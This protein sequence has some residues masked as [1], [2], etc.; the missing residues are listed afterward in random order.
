MAINIGNRE[1]VGWVH[2]ANLTGA[3][4]NTDGTPTIPLTPT[5]PLRKHPHYIRDGEV[6]MLKSEFPRTNMHPLQRHITETTWA[7]YYVAEQPVD[8][9]ILSG[10]LGREPLRFAILE[11]IP[12][13]DGG[14]PQGKGIMGALHSS[15]SGAVMWYFI[16]QGE[17]FIRTAPAIGNPGVPIY[18]DRFSQNGLEE[19]H[20]Q[21]N[22]GSYPN[23]GLNMIRGMRLAGFSTHP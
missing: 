13:P 19:I 16:S 6:Q 11:G 1:A 2:E 4:N 7:S 3:G 21:L 5:S 17:N 8:F 18:H 14:W 22:I 15:R 20:T 10:Q 23:P 12:H 9:Q